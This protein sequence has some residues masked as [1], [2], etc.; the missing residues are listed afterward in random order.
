MVTLEIKNDHCIFLQI[1]SGARTL[2]IGTNE[3]ERGKEKGQWI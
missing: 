1:T 2:E 3:K